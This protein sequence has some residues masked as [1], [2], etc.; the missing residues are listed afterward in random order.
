MKC[1]FYN[2]IIRT[3]TGTTVQAVAIE[4]GII[5]AVGSD[6]E[7]LALGNS[8]TEKVDLKGQCLLPGFND[9]HC[10]LLLTGMNFVRLDLKG[11]TSVEG[12]IARGRRYIEESALPEGQ[13]VIGFGFDQNQFDNPVLPDGS[14]AEAISSSHPV[15]LDRICG[16]VGAANR[17]ALRQVKFTAQTEIQGGIL[18]KDANG[19]LTGILREAALD[20]FKSRIP[21]VG[22]EETM[23][24]IQATSS[25]ANA[26]GI[27][28]MQTDDLE[29]VPLETL[30]EAFARLEK[31][32]KLTIR[33]FEEV[34]AARRQVLERFLSKE[35]RTGWG[36]NYFKIG[37]I[38]LLTDGSLGAR[39]AYLRQDYSDDP[40]NQGVAIYSQ[41]E[42]DE[43][44]EVAHKADMQIAFH[45]IGD[46]AIEQCVNAVEKAM[47]ANSKDLRHRIVHC[48]IADEELFDR[49]KKLGMGVDIQP[50]F[51]ASD[52][53]LVEPRL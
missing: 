3:M 50:S 13:W 46:G 43:M 18:D 5:S 14:V 39:T 24:I 1:I 52:M 45:A 41:S 15:L 2:G 11:V 26:F 34:Q 49:I 10:H 29:G 7:I 23:S 16:H 51:T 9:S 33:V 19:N 36:S 22:V 38:K 17:L 40:G 8:E 44:V 30:L 35:M 12:I 20:C 4:E 31:E 48:Q 47:I 28:S 32:G 25:Y 42:L 27:T 6:D 21:K 37:N 53:L